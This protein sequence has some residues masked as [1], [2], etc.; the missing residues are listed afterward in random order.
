MHRCTALFA[1]DVGSAFA[2]TFLRT[3]SN[4]FMELLFGALLVRYAA[5]NP[6]NCA[7]VQ[8]AA[9]ASRDLGSVAAYAVGLALYGRNFVYPFASWQPCTAFFSM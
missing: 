6:I 3:M 9:V 2:I 7:G 8:S 1:K 5:L 4:A